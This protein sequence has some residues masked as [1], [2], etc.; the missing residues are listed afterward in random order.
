MT[1]LGTKSVTITTKEGQE[2][3]EG[4]P[5]LELLAGA[6]TAAGGLYLATRE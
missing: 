5:W 2:P 4:M 1:K 3:E 6:S